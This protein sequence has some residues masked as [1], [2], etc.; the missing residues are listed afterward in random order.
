[1]VEGRAGAGAVGEV[2]DGDVEG[3]GRA[4]LGGPGSDGVG[5]G[6]AGVGGGEGWGVGGGERGRGICRQRDR[7]CPSLDQGCRIRNGLTAN[8]STSQHRKLMTGKTL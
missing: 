5:L 6:S 7:F 2:G 8:T 3:G 4:G 1:M